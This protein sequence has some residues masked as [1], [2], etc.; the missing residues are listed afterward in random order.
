METREKYW[1][2]RYLTNQTQWDTGSITS[3]LKSYFDQLQ[4]KD[5]KIL[6][7]GAGNGYEAEYLFHQNFRHV[8][9]ADI[10]SIPLGNF[11]QRCPLFPDF[12]LIH[13]DFFTLNMQFDLIIEQT[14]FC[15]LHPSQRP[16]YA[17]QMYHLL[18]PGGKLVGL[19]F[20]DPLNSDHPPYGGN[21]EEYLK[22][23]LPYFTVKYFDPCYNSIPPRAGRELFISLIK[24]EAPPVDQNAST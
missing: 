15:A 22:Y 11:K 1:T 24:K 10:S 12:Q 16:D 14:F 7:P 20:D 3:P 17:R 18:R 9:L 13:A 5:V 6:I 2:D 19:L 4:D 8:Y 21:R 23:F